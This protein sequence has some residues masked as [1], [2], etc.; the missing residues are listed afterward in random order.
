[1]EQLVFIEI[2]EYEWP[3]YIGLVFRFSNFWSREVMVSKH[4][5]VNYIRIFY[6]TPL[7]RSRHDEKML[8]PSRILRKLVNIERLK[9]KGCL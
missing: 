2:W 9:E 8:S 6:A 7:K 3:G 4:K 1:M 5:R